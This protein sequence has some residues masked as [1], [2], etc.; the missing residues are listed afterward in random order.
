VVDVAWNEIS[1]TG[2]VLHK[3]L[4]AL[5]KCFTAWCKYYH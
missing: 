4:I 5:T 3:F 2:Y 1:F